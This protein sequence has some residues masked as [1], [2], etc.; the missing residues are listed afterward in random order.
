MPSTDPLS[1]ITNTIASQCPILTQ[2]TALSSRNK[3]LR[4]L[5]LVLKACAFDNISFV[6]QCHER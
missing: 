3:Q 4:Q 5:D 6:S 1:L 2:D